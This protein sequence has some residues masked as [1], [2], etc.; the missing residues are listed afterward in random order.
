MPSRSDYSAIE[1]FITRLSSAN[2][3]KLVEENAKDLAKYGLDKPAMTV[4]IGAGSAKTVLEVGK[5]ENGRDLREGRLA[6][7]RVHGRHARCRPI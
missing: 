3:S 4:T 2:M 1:G 6:A 5:T 7:D